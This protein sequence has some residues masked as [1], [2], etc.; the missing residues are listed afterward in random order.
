LSSTA[1][2]TR[3]KKVTIN[4]AGKRILVYGSRDFTDYPL[5]CG[6][7]DVSSAGATAEREVI[8]HGEASGANRR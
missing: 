8:I 7:L 1:S 4:I 2:A 6:T 3:S 5:L